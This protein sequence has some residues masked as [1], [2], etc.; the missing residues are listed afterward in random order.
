MSVS[1]HIRIKSAGTGKKKGRLKKI[2]GFDNYLADTKG[3]IY[4]IGKFGRLRQ[5]TQFLVP[6]SRYLRVYLTQGSYKKNLYVHNL[7]IS[8][9]RRYN[10]ERI[11]VKHK[12]DNSLN[13]SLSNLRLKERTEYDAGENL[14]KFRIENLEEN[15]RQ[16]LGYNT[17]ARLWKK[18]LKLKSQGTPKTVINWLS[19]VLKNL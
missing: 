10:P 4:V 8:A 9:F 17:G 2:P 7:V 13:N 15:F 12:D 5:L 19:V 3:R 11:I 14:E 18:Y 6:N 1:K 16:K